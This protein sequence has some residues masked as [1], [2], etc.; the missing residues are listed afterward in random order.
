[1]WKNIQSLKGTSLPCSIPYLINNNTTY[2]IPQNIANV[3]GQNFEKVS[4]NNSYDPTFQK[5]KSETE[6]TSLNFQSD[7]S[8]S[9]N[10]PFSLEELKYTLQ[11][12]I[13]NSSPGPDEIHPFMIKHLPDSAKEQLLNLFNKIW[14]SDSF[15]IFVQW[16]L[17]V[18]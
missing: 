4:A 7:N 3:L 6:K 14:T 10:H 8:E 15:P 16:S 13:K 9:Y 18:S 1:M 5:I 11:H 12:N 17:K 2:D